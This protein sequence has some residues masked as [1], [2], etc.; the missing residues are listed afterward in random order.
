M[1]GT[2]WLESVT[3][4]RRTS[5]RSYIPG[6]H[7]FKIRVQLSTTDGE[8]TV[9]KS[10]GPQFFWQAVMVMLIEYLAPSSRIQ[11]REPGQ[12]TA[13]AA[14]DVGDVD[15]ARRERIV[16]IYRLTYKITL[17]LQGLE[18]RRE[19]E[20]ART[21]R[22]QSD[23]IF[24]AARLRETRYR[25]TIPKKVIRN[26]YAFCDFTLRSCLRA[27]IS[28]RVMRVPSR[29]SKCTKNGCEKLYFIP[30]GCGILT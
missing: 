27:A 15:N 12:S 14:D 8:E 19:F 6:M 16:P 23:N 5:P 30:I 17:H 29:T 20:R 3:T 22:A 2:I 26:T 24:N 21:V 28:R 4:S 9:P 13:P 10:D 11:G 1:N 18:Q 7:I 25:V